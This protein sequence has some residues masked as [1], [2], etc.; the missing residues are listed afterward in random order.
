MPRIDW[1]K[2]HAARAAFVLYGR[3][4][5]IGSSEIFADVR[6]NF[7]RYLIK[8]NVRHEMISGKHRHILSNCLLGRAR[9][10]Y[11]MNL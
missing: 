11:L 7:G 10:S 3:Y 9:G 1:L 8:I 2:V 4:N 6:K 5:L